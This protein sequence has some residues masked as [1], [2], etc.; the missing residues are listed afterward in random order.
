MSLTAVCGNKHIPVTS[1]PVMD[2]EG[3]DVNIIGGTITTMPAPPSATSSVPTFIYD[4]SAAEVSATAAASRV[5]SGDF[6]NRSAAV[7]YIQ[8]HNKATAPATNDVPL[9]SYE[10][11]A[12]GGTM[13]LDSAFFFYGFEYFSAGIGLGISSTPKVYT[14]APGF[15]SVDVNFKYSTP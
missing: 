15:A 13:I 14:A 7:V 4:N 8:F 5:Y 12:N 9:L 1:T 6:T 10:V 2:K 11:P 3:L